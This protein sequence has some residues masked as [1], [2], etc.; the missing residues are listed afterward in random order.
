[1]IAPPIISKCRAGLA[2]LVLGIVIA[3]FTSGAIAEDTG[4]SCCLDLEER[5]LD[6]EANTARI[7]SPRKAVFSASGALDQE[8]TY[9]NDGTE[10]DVYQTGI[11]SQ[12]AHFKFGSNIKATDALSFGYLLR[13]Q[14]FAAYP[15]LRLNDPEGIDQKSDERDFGPDI[16]MLYWYASHEDLGS[17]TVGRQSN[18]AKSAAM[19]TDLS[20]TQRFDNPTMLSAFPQ[21]IVRSNGDLDPSTLTW[22]EFSFCHSRNMPVGSDCDGISLNG[23]RYDTPSLR[24]LVLSA[25]WGTDDFW[26]AAARYNGEFGGF[27]LALGAAFA[28]TT[29]ETQFGPPPSFEKT[30]DY[31]QAGAYLEH[32]E[33]GLLV[34][35]IWGLEDNHN[36]P[37][38]NGKKTADGD[39]WGFKAGV[40]KKWNTHGASILYGDYTRYED[41]LGTSALGLGFTSSAFERFGVGIAQE[42]D[43]ASM[44]LY[45]KYQHYQV[46]AEGL[47]LDPSLFR[48]EE[49]DF[50]SIGDVITF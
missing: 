37:L 24:G 50:I 22:A 11:A 38:K 21:F 1:M 19:L 25:S 10:T 2:G 42:F 27:K 8:I 7:S 5:I 48:L 6:L 45:L 13:I 31:Y 23:I 36:T 41:E 46:E 40:R 20:G 9:W 33:T 29:D 16:H 14:L 34:H 30:S 39:H 12:V 47:G 26:E 17:I 44:T 18:A 35:A 3:R 15:F 49:A 43:N 32:L 28:H 4:A